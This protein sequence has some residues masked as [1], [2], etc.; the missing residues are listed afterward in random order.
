[1]ILSAQSIRNRCINPPPES[2]MISPFH[3]RVEMI[4]T[5]GRKLSYGLGPCSYDARIATK[6]ILLPN[7]MTN[8]SSFEMLNMP[9]NICGRVMDKSSWARM[10]VTVQNT[11]IDPGFR[12][13]MTLELCNHT[14]APIYIGDKWPIC[15]FV[16]EFLDE[17]TELPY[18]G[19]YQNQPNKPIEAL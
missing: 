2:E 14:N 5:N 15:Q 19:K 4:I 3:E 9:H 8:V 13:Y 17:P 18:N 16:F 1:M 6:I 11:H 10:G 7:I 12:G